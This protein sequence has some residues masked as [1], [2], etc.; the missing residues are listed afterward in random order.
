MSTREHVY[1]VELQHSLSLEIGG[2]VPCAGP[3]G[4]TFARQALGVEEGSPSLSCTEILGHDR[5]CSRA[6]GHVAAPISITALGRVR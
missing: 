2:E 1:G 5:H 3:S 6:H 4:P